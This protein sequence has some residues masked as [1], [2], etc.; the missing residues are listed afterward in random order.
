MA[1]GMDFESLVAC[2]YGPLFQFAFS[3][4]RDETDD[5]RNF[6]GGDALGLFQFPVAAPFESFVP[7]I[8][9]ALAPV[10]K[11]TNWRIVIS[12]PACLD[13]CTP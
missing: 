5:C 6:S 1:E 13:I 7:Q 8:C 9:A 12:S 2:Y 3:L 10:W 11:R 4:A